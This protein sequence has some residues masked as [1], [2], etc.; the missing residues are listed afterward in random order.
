MEFMSTCTHAVAEGIRLVTFPLHPK[1]H[2]LPAPWVRALW[3][4]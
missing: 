2:H 3:A 1:P 4:E